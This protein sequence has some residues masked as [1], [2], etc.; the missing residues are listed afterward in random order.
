MADIRIK[1]LPTTATQTASDDFIALDGTVNGTRK[2]DASAPSFKTSVTS[3][4]VVA[5]ATTN[6]TLAGGTSGAS[7]VLGQGAAA[8]ATLTVNNVA[9]F[10]V[11]KA[12]GNAYLNVTRASKATG[13][14][15]VSLV[16]GT[17]G[18]DWILYQNAN[19]DDLDFFGNSANRVRMT[20]TGN[21]LIGTTTDITGAGNLAVAGGTV[22]AGAAATNLTLSGGASGASLMLGQGTSGNINLTPKG[23]GSVTVN[24]TVSADAE[25]FLDFVNGAGTQARI[26]VIND[27]VATLRGQMQFYTNDG[28][29]LAEKMRLTRTGN[30]LIGGTTDI[31][32]SGGLK[33]YGTTAASSTT[34]GALQ[35]AGGVGVAGAVFSGGTMNAGA[36]LFVQGRTVPSSG[37]GLETYYASNIS[38]LLSYDRTSSAYKGFSLDGSTQDFYISGARKLGID[39]S[40]NTTVYS[41]TASTGVGTGALQVA[42]GVGV[43]GAGYFGGAINATGSIFSSGGSGAPS[44]ASSGIQ[45]GN[46]ASG[47]TT[48]VLVNSAGAANS[49]IADFNWTGTALQGRFTNDAYSAATNWI[50]VTGNS[51]AVSSVNFPATTSASSSIVGALTI[52]NGTAAT[53]VAIGGGNVNAGGT[54]TVSGAATVGGDLVV[55]RSANAPVIAQVNNPNTGTGAYSVFTLTNA[56]TNGR[57]FHFGTGWTTASQYIQDSTL[58]ESN[59]AGGL[60]FSSGGSGLYRFFGGGIN[61][62]SLTGTSTASAVMAFN[63]T[64]ASTGVG[65]GALQVA[66]GIYAGAASVFGGTLNVA[67][68]GSFGGAF[69]TSST[70]RILG[71][72]TTGPSQFGIDEQTVFQSSATTAGR[73]V[74]AVVLTAAAS[75]TMA[76][77]SAFYAATP[78]LGAG[79]AIT[80]QHGLRILNQ[81]AAGVTNAYGIDIAAQSGAATTNIGLRNAGITSLTN[82]TA[83]SAGAGALVVSGGLSTGAASYFGGNITSASSLITQT[84]A[85]S[86]A[87][88]IDINNTAT[89]GTN[90]ASSLFRTR[91]I[92]GYTS[93][94]GGTGDGTSASYQTQLGVA[95]VLQNQGVLISDQNNG[96]LIHSTNGTLKFGTG[97]TGA[98]RATIDSTSATFAGII[99]PQQA[100][101]ASAPTYVK[102]AIYF[103]TTLNKLRVGGATG[104]ETIT[105][106]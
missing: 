15:A 95:T 55:V 11:T 13:Q 8:T 92:P 33:V 9:G 49:K 97:N 100:A 50:S 87:S 3:P 99:L 78:S 69:T 19:S 47:A 94:F 44:S 88:V 53:S 34:T 2:I 106:V 31:T 77:G 28:T 98:V 60:N 65:T 37:A 12:T 74:S 48:L 96:I 23:A 35:V 17:G 75:F 26:G 46:T 85:V 71:S 10:T 39:A 18:V 64:T 40:G 63:G 57:I 68:V 25:K 22:T 41:S 38:G 5:P 62:A 89:T 83:G 58:L 86:G 56:S 81:G 80:T 76:E 30:L 73:G 7:L 24:S 93:W 66:G 54:L 14:A 16:G 72:S 102:G 42:G 43:A 52:G 105:S 21:L 45:L 29:T 90:G 82:T 61:L 79:S 67:N 1:D 70:L 36:G 104:W 6:L 4:S 91:S 27:G 32:G 59:G 51:T 84:S 101:T 20:S 103:D